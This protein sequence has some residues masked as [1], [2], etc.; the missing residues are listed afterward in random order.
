METF[1]PNH[2]LLRRV[3]LALGS[4]T[5]IG[6]ASLSS[7]STAYGTMSNFD[8]VNDTGSETHGF[9]I[10]I[11]DCHSTDIT[12]TYDYNH[13]GKP[14]LFESVTA[15]GHPMV[16]VHYASAKNPNG[17][18][19][20]HTIVPTGPIAPTMG[21][22]F[23]NPA[24]NFGG[25]HFGV[26]VR[27]S[28]PVVRYYWLLDDGAGNLVHGPQ[29]L[30]AQPVYVYAPAVGQVV[31]RIEQPE[32]PEK[33]VLEFGPASWVK[34]IITSHIN[35]AKVKLEDL[36][37]DDPGHRQP[38]QNGEGSETEVEW[39]LMQTD[40][41]AADK[42][43][44]GHLDGKG[45]KLAKGDE[46]V[47]RRYEFYKYIGPVDAETGEAVADTVAADGI[48][49]V[50]S[51]T[52]ADHIDPATG[53]FVTKTVDLSKIKI[54]GAFFGAQMSGFDAKPNLSL[55]ENVQD[56]AF[57]VPYTKRTV[58]IGG[59]TP[60][61]AAVSAGALPPGLALNSVSGILSG[62]PTVPGVFTFTV[63]A[64]D[65]SGVSVTHDYK[66]TVSGESIHV[67]ANPVA[68][69][70]VTGA[71]NYALGA[72]IKLTA[73]PKAGYYFINW[74]EGAAV[75]STLPTYSF[76]GKVSRTLVAN[77]G[78]YDVVKVLASPAIGGTVSGGGNFK[79]GQAVTVVATP[80]AGYGFSCWKDGATVVSN[81][82]TYKF[83]AAANRT[84]VAV[85]APK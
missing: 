14:A 50:G 7:A 66:L 85:F 75:V 28:T 27:V 33:P 45:Q 49:G 1:S 9:D 18:W 65:L 5:S 73:T 11:E 81:L 39:Q 70:I 32:P 26:G 15:A 41:G 40:F 22:Q 84:L 56:G 37:G 48:H 54:V 21:H 12:Y 46:V 63:K 67:S 8:C 64:T 72:P 47:T 35:P 2:N 52:Y 71:G 59:Q 74:K 82:A 6:L 78:L 38:W 13:Y 62:T 42:G 68:G 58:V 36:V 57:R 60:F 4:L 51:V 76:T 19:A 3:G 20:A 16:T 53:E 24:I 17:T 44:N 83:T 43:K 31:A 79:P 77:F 25:E 10:E 29:V 61:S 69:G 80:K 55:T 30:V 34:E 23:T